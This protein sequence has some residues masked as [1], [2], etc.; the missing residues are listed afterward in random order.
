MKLR[1]LLAA[2]AIVSIAAPALATVK[3]YDQ[4]IENGN[5]G[6]Q[7]QYST[8]LCP[9]IQ[10]TP[11]AVVGSNTLTDTGGGTVTMTEHSTVPVT[12]V[13]FGVG[14]LTGIFGPGSFVFVNSRS[15]WSIAGTPPTGSGSTAPGGSVAWGVISGWESTGQTFCI[16]S[17]QT[18]CTGGTMVP[19]G[20]TTPAPAP[21]SPTYDLGTWS[22]DTEGDLTATSFITGTNNGGTSNRQRIIRGA[23]VGTSV[24]ALPLVGA[25]VLALG[26]AIAGTRTV[27]RKK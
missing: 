12:Q 23:Y 4:D 27:L 6:D 19:H 16:A 18:I 24:P 9:P 1:H 5:S 2:A 26:L 21:N 7:L 11:N 3:V 8:T 25:G 10:S 17:P 14:A 22:F 20:V 15:T 13:N